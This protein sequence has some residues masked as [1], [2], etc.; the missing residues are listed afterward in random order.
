MPAK[1]IAEVF[2]LLHAVELSQRYN[3]ADSPGGRRPSGRSPPR[4]VDNAVGTGAAIVKGSEGRATAHQHPGGHGGDEGGMRACGIS[5]VPS[6]QQTAPAAEKFDYLTLQSSLIA[7]L[8]T[9]VYLGDD[10]VTVHE[11]SRWRRN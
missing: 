1:D 8:K 10:A 2:Q 11:I 4:A 6:V 5:T 7:R 3:I 9:E